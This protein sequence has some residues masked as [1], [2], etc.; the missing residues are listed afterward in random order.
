M[1]KKAVCL[2][3]GGLDSAV[4]AFIAKDMGY[5]LFALSFYLWSET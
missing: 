3:S 1:G 5:D 2:I 4:S